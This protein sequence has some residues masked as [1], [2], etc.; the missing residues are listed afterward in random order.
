VILDKNKYNEGTGTTEK[1]ATEDGFD[2]EDS[3]IIFQ[4]AHITCEKNHHE[5]LSQ[6]VSESISAGYKNFNHPC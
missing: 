1:M 3:Y 5:I 2:V 6:T 4:I